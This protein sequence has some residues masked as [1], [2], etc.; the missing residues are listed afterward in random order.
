[1]S[2][3]TPLPRIMVAPNGARRGKADHPELPVTLGEIVACAGACHGA[4]AD[5]LHAHV[6]DAEGK[7][8]LD[9]GLYRELIARMAEDVP[10]MAVQITTEAGGRFDPPTQRALLDALTP[11]G[12]SAALRE[13]LAD[14]DRAAARR[15]Y[16]H[17]SEA[18]IAL[19]HILY[20]PAEID[21]LAAE[22][23]AGTIPGGALQLLFVLG[24]YTA[25]EESDPADLQGFLDRMAANDIQADWALCAFGRSETACLAA[26]L[27]AGGKARVGFENNVFMADGRIAR[28]NTE[29]VAEIAALPGATG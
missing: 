6:R 25:G 8:T 9:P 17:A 26:V 14:G 29:R 3:L 15:F 22:R 21:R 27:E 4:G 11:E 20:E 16:H 7:H 1:M 24:R 10:G 19:Q 5:G 13:I 2:R 28:D 12:A 18:G 23:R